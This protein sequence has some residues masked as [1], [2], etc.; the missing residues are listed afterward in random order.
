VAHTEAELSL[1]VFEKRELRRTFGTKMD[2]LREEWRKLHKE[3][4]NDIFSLPNN[5]G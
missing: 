4:N 5:F 3:E 1:R 2:E